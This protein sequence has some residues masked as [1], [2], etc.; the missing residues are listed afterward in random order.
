LSG[1]AWVAFK[2]AKLRGETSPQF[3]SARNAVDR[4]TRYQRLVDEGKKSPREA[5][6][7]RVIAMR[8]VD[9]WYMAAV[10]HAE[11][12]LLALPPPE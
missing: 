7:Q 6:T 9:E 11:R 1:P 8:T 12:D 4:S 2:A 5:D 10:V 3:L